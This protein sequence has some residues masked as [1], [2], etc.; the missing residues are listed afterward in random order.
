MMFFRAAT[1][2][3]RNDPACG[4]IVPLPTMSARNTLPIRARRMEMAGRMVTSITADIREPSG[5]RRSSWGLA[6][7]NGRL[8]S[9]E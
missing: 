2:A 1:A 6:V 5:S 9:P 8:D 4:L 7:S 3:A